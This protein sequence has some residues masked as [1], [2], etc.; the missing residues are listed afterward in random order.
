MSKCV[1]NVFKKDLK[2]AAK[3]TFSA[4]IADFEKKKLTKT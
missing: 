4:E 3:T 1:Q 2:M